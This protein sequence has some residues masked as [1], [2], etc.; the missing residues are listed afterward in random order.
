MI[1]YN[2]KNWGLV[3]KS[4]L[5]LG[6]AYNIRELIKIQTIILLYSLIVV[7]VRLHVFNDVKNYPIELNVTFLSLIG[8]IMGLTLVFR[9]NSSYDRWWEGR[10]L[11]G[12]L[13]NDSRTMASNFYALLRDDFESRRYV[14]A[15]IANFAYSLQGHLREAINFDLFDDAGNPENIQQLKK[16]KHI[17]HRIATNIFVKMEELY[18]K[19]AFSD[20]DKINIKEQIEQ[21]INIMGA[22]ERIKNTPIPFSHVSFIKS[23][24]ILYCLILP[25]GMV[26]TFHYYTIPAVFLISYALAGVEIISEEIEQPFGTDANDLPLLHISNIIKQNVYEIMDVPLD[27]EL[28]SAKEKPNMII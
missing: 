24:I 20:V 18:K 26:D 3:I 17:P 5:G 2:S 25:L 8:V 12:A 23:F 16:A 22:C 11:W 21:F 1:I 4:L 7:Y 15:Q 28:P 10:K 27:K 19:S 13:I 14:A 9:T 6:Y